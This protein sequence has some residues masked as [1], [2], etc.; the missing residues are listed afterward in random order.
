MFRPDRGVSEPGRNRMG[1]FNLAFVVGEQEGFR[2]LQYAEASP[3]KTGRMFAAANA[4]ATGFDADHSDMSILQKG[5]EQAD[6][7]TATADA[8][9]EQI[10]KPF[11]AF[12]NLAARLNADNALKIA[13]HHRV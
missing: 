13:H 6:G 9:D 8:R 2:P 5:M 1:R 10:R 12:E 11:F 4:F 3:L 7:D